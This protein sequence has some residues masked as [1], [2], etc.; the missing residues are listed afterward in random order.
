MRFKI[1]YH[2]DESLV[3]VL[4]E[5]GMNDIRI[6]DINHK[7]KFVVVEDL[8]EGFIKEVEYFK[9]LTLIEDSQYEIEDLENKRWNRR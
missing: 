1:R 8:P 7:R 6:V 3:L 4:K 2:D 9:N 5:L